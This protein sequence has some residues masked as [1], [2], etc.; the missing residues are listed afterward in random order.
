MLARSSGDEY[1]SLLASPSRQPYL[2]RFIQ[3]PDNI[4]DIEYYFQRAAFSRLSIDVDE[5]LQYGENGYYD[6][7]EDALVKKD[8]NSLLAICR[9][10]LREKML[11]EKTAN[12]LVNMT[13]LAFDLDKEFVSPFGNNGF[14][15]YRGQTN[16]DY[17]L[18]PSFY[19]GLSAVSDTCIDSDYVIYKANGNKRN[20]ANSYRQ[21]ISSGPANNYEM[22]SFMQH[23]CSFSPFLD[24]SKNQ[25]VALSFALS[26]YEKLN[27]FNE[28]ASSIFSLAVQGRGTTIDTNKRQ[29]NHDLSHFQVYYLKNPIVLGETYS[30]DKFSKNGRTIQKVHP[31]T[32]ST[33]TEIVFNLVPHFVLFDLPTNDRMRI[34]KGT[35]V[36]FD[37]FV[38]VNRNVLF[39]LNPSFFVQKYMIPKNSSPSGFKIRLLEHIRNQ[40]RECQISYLLDPYSY[41]SNN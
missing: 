36:L 12:H 24:F 15:W 41:F 11:D 21:V 1:L 38:M 16:A 25:D 30:F 4:S 10:V 18:V 5:N 13:P 35:F 3:N 37:D 17:G 33:F 20:L 26:N 6:F 34:Q 29:A 9:L 40:K 8:A 2:L 28:I 7:F 31:I 14:F 22:F 23:A 39:N 32:F 19:R 27:D